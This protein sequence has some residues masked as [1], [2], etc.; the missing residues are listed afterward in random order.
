[1]KENVTENKLVWH[2]AGVG[3]LGSLIAGSFQ[4]QGLGVRLI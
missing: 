1:M 2:I 3:A 4:Q